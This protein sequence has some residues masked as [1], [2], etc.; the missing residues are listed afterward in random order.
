MPDTIQPDTTPSSATKPQEDW[1]ARYKGLSTTYNE[2]RN[3]WATELE[4]LRKEYEVYKPFKDKWEERGNELKNLMDELA[5]VKADKDKALSDTATSQDV[6][7]R[8]KLFTTAE[9]AELIPLEEKGLLRKDLK[10]DS[11]KDHL[12][13]WKAQLS[14]TQ[15]ADKKSGITPSAPPL[16]KGTK[17]MDLEKEAFSAFAN[18]DIKGYNELMDQALLAKE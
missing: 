11:L 10:G 17:K 5:S 8:L 4:G 18:G 3:K 12:N 7:D 1:E 14:A 15:R 9:F 6:I 2:A 16:R 13:E